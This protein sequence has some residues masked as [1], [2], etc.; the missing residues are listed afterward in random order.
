MKVGVISDLH[1]GYYPAFLSRVLGRELEQ[2]RLK[3]VFSVFAEEKVDTVAILGD[4]LHSWRGSGGWIQLMGFLNLI[5]RYRIPAFMVRGNHDILL[6]KVYDYIEELSEGYLFTFFGLKSMES[7]API[8]IEEESHRGHAYT[9]LK[10]LNTILP[11]AIL[12]HASSVM[13]SEDI[14]KVEENIWKL[15]MEQWDRKGILFAHYFLRSR[16]GSIVSEITKREPVVPD[17]RLVSGNVYIFAGHD[18]RP[19]SDESGKAHV[20]G[21]MFPRDAR[22]GG[23]D[24]S[25]GIIEVQE[26]PPTV[27]YHPM[28][29]KLPYHIEY[30]K[31]FNVAQEAK[32]WIENILEEKE[33]LSITELFI[34]DESFTLRTFY[35][36][37]ASKGI[38]IKR[39]QIMRIGRTS[40]K[41]GN[42]KNIVEIKDIAMLNITDAFRQYVNTHDLS[43][44]KEID[45]EELV[46]ETVDI[47]SEIW[48]KGDEN[49]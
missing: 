33:L 49:A 41:T 1:L 34:K 5:R 43:L 32:E 46:K 4:L 23:S 38:D 14:H 6:P 18:H 7:R 45:K 31:I 24:V 35:D 16:A 36:Y 37:L 19:Y 2:E 40:T 9:F 3:Q 44:P 17:K 25:F 27:K 12:P 39:L 42:D 29:L 30:R 22:L 13:P 10:D 21:S 8:S 48:K 47:L 20:I 15:M 26:N 28:T 11:V